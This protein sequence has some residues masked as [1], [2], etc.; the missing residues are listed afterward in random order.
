MD[1]DTYLDHSEGDVKQAI[2]QF[3]ARHAYQLRQPWYIEGLRIEEPPSRSSDYSRGRI[4]IELKRKRGKTRLRISVGRGSQSTKLA[5][6]LQSYLQDDRAYHAQC[7]PMCPKCGSPVA[8][9][10]ARYCGR[11]GR[12]LVTGVKEEPPAAT[13]VRA[14]PPPVPSV[15]VRVPIAA[16]SRSPVVVERDATPEPAAETVEA[17]VEAQVVEEPEVEA[18]ESSNVQPTPVQPEPTASTPAP[19]EVEAAA[20]AEQDAIDPPAEAIAEAEA[21]PDLRDENRPRQALAED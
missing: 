10:H 3:A 7:P 18:A 9:L 19:D 12:K 21:E 6:N 4:D 1:L 5:Y 17:I 16:P 13:P 2:V 11:C 15:P 20:E 8:N 14:A